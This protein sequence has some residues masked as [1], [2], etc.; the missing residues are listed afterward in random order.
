MRVWDAG[1]GSACA[2]EGHSSRV[3]RWFGAPTVPGRVG[4]YDNTVRVD[5]GTGECVRTLEGHSACC[6]VARPDGSQVAS[7]SNDTRC[8]GRGHGECVRTPEGHSFRCCRGLEPR[9]VPGR[10]G[11]VD[12]RCACGRGHGGCVRTL[13]GHSYGCSGLE[14]RRVPGRVGV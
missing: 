13:E 10:V 12:R 9:R 5:A 6:S 8:A 2:L 11:V 1:T 14:P 3:C 7:G 4:V